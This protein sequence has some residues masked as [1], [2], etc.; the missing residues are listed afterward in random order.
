MSW[1]MLLL[2]NFGPVDEHNPL[3]FSGENDLLVVFSSSS[4]FVNSVHAAQ[5][6]LLPPPFKNFMVSS[7]AKS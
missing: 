1:D 4:T 7:K 6:S 2:H 5:S 3:M